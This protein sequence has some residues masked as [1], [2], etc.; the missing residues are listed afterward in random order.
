MQAHMLRD[1]LGEIQKKQKAFAIR[2]WWG[3]CHQPAA[4]EH[5]NI[6]NSMYSLIHLAS[7]VKK[8]N[9]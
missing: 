5:V 1:H 8:G 7:F 6:L 2:I 3:L 9:F 4:L